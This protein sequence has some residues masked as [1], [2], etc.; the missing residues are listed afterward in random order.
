MFRRGD[1]VPASGLTLVRCFPLRSSLSIDR[2]HDTLR[3]SRPSGGFLVGWGGR[4]RTFEYGIQSPAPYRLATP[5]LFPPGPLDLPRLGGRPYH[6]N[7]SGPEMVG[8][9]TGVYHSD[10]RRSASAD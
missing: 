5:H 4:I 8:A 2:V 10:M 7:S 6:V 3:P 9:N 1:F